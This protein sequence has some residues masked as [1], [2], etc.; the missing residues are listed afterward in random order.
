MTEYA[1]EMHVDGIVAKVVATSDDGRTCYF[2]QANGSHGWFR[3]EEEN[4]SPPSLGQVLLLRPSYDAFDLAPAHLFPE[5]IDPKAVETVVCVRRKME[6]ETVV[7]DAGKLRLVPTT[8]SPPYDEG[9]TVVLSPEGKVVRVLSTKPLRLFETPRDEIDIGHLRVDPESIEETFEDFAGMDEVAD[10]ART[11]L[12][13]TFAQATEVAKMGGRPIRGVLFSGPPGTGKTMLARVIAKRAT[14]SFYRI[15]G[16]EIL[17]K[18]Y[19]E[20]EAVLRRIFVD[21]GKRGQAV[22]FFDEIDSIA[23]SRTS[24]THEASQRLVGQLLTLMDGFSRDEQVVVV[25]ATNRPDSLDRA[26]RRRGRFDWEVRFSLPGL[27]SREVI[28]E[29]SAPISARGAELPHAEIA[30]LT[31]GWTPADLTGI[32]TEAVILALQDKREKIHVEDYR[33]GRRRVEH[34]R[35]QR[36]VANG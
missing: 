32:W 19:G 34:E 31:D 35:R 2:A 22:I 24:S 15:S 8:D 21:A 6:A 17:S 30:A 5:K 27:H 23:A 25:A 4:G 16:P 29:R 11:L 13:L 20:S 10:K 3:V 36:Q 7:E 1:N 18:W 14:A 33:E 28:L 26:L 12:E 9:N